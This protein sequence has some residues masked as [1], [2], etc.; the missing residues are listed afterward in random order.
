[1]WTVAKYQP[2]FAEGYKMI[3]YEDAVKLLT[4]PYDNKLTKEQYEAVKSL[5]N[6][7]EYF[8]KAF[9]EKKTPRAD[10]FFPNPPRPNR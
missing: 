2:R 7:A 4:R 8:Q 10:G 6:R 9:N 3:N 1:M 5:I